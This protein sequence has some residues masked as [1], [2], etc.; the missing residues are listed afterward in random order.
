VLFDLPLP[1]ALAL[2]PQE[3]ARALQRKGLEAREECEYGLLE[4]RIRAGRRPELMGRY[5]VIAPPPG[6]AAPAVLVAGQPVEAAEP[7]EDCAMEALG[8]F[9][10]GTGA[11][12]RE[13]LLERV[14]VVMPFLRE[15]LAG[16]VYFHHGPCARLARPRAG[17][18]QREESLRTGYRP[19]SFAH[20][21]LVF[22]GNGHYADCGLAEGIL[23]GIL[24]LK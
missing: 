9:A 10:P 16:E 7:G 17:R 8:F 11:G 13:I 14:S 20:Q 12:A 5:L 2:L 24:A 18:R 15:S 19:A 23:T 3:T 6:G 1:E 21:Q 4:L 22:L